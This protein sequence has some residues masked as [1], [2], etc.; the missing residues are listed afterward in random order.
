MAATRL[1][2]THA[3]D[4]DAIEAT[5]WPRVLALA[6]AAPGVEHCHRSSGSALMEC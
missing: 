1:E 5:I 3:S 6:L 2:A 4:Q